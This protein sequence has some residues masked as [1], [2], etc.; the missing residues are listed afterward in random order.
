MTKTR[1]K[2]FII[3]NN[4]EKFEKAIVFYLLN[5]GK[6]FNTLNLSDSIELYRD[7]LLIRNN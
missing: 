5:I 4:L 7:F 3:V 2:V 1:P 6:L